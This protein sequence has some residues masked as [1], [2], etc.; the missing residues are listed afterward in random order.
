M[1]RMPPIN[2]RIFTSPNAHKA[3]LVAHPRT[4]IPDTHLARARILRADATDGERVLWARLRQLKA[5]GFHF[6]RQTRIGPY[7]TDFA[8]KGSRLVVELDGS[9]HRVAENV[10]YDEIRTA[11]LHR[12]GYRVLRF[13]NHE[14]FD[15]RDGVAEA[16]L[17]A[18]T[19]TRPAARDDLPMLG[20]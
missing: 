20:R 15:N 6:R 17:R 12:R 10:V 11:F 19:P 13:A 8:C 16:I 4:R 7:I 18:L 5:Q 2:R 9:Q 1:A 3:V 14:V